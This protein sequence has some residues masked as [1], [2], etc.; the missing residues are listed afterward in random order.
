MSSVVK[1][2]GQNFLPLLLLPYFDM[3]G[4]HK[5]FHRSKSF[6]AVDLIQ[7]QSNESILSA[8]FSRLPSKG[9]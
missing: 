2:A 7:L 1:V 8:E 3:H 6:G 9:V 5:T 4:A